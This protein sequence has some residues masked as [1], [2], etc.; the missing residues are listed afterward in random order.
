[1]PL[2]GGVLLRA[3]RALGFGRHEADDRYQ[4]RPDC[5]RTSGNVGTALVNETE[6]FPHE[7]LRTWKRPRRDDALPVGRRN[8]AT[9]HTTGH[10]ACDAT[11]L[12]TTMLP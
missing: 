7:R 10:V 6:R 8:H 11:W 5:T 1:M 9:L 2:L 4:R 12:M 3:Y